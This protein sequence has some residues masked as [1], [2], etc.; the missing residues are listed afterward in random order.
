AVE[1]EI[2]EEIEMEEP[3]A[4]STYDD[5]SSNV[6]ASDSLPES[7]MDLGEMDNREDDIMLVGTPRSAE[8]QVIEP[9]VDGDLPEGGDEVG[10]VPVISVLPRVLNQ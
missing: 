7:W 1:P 6:S 8:F 3:P 2:G 4:E 9:L 10:P 5:Q